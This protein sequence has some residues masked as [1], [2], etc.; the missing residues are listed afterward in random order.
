MGS[1]GGYQEAT[2]HPWPCLLFLLP[3]LVAYEAG[4]T[5]LGGEHPEVLRNGAD[6]WLRSA[7][8][9]LMGTL[10]WVPPAL[11]VLVFVVWAWCRRKERPGQLVNVLSGMV[12]ESVAFAL[13]LWGLGRALTPL[14]EGAPVAGP[15]AALDTSGPLRP[16]V[17]EAGSTLARAITY[18]GAG[19]YEEALFRLVLFSGLLLLFRRLDL[20]GPWALGLAAVASAVVFSAAHH[21]G[22]HGQPYSN[23]V[24]LFRLAAGLYFVWLYQARGFGIAVGAHACYNVMVSFQ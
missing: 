18:L 5:L 3:L 9:L 20:S 24:F 12:L 13:V 14:L 23:S 1:S 4:V 2:R 17:P 21:L 22:A 15:Q 10:F 19:I 16:E 11:L 6:A 8:P 7:H